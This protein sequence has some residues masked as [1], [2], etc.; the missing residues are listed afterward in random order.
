[1]NRPD[2]RRSGWGL[3]PAPAWV[4]AIAAL[5]LVPPAF[6]ALFVHNHEHGSLVFTFWFYVVMGIV[7]AGY[8]LFAGYVYGDAR[9]R[10]MRATVW[11]VIVVVI[12]NLIGFLLYFVL[13]KPILSPCPQ[14]GQGVAQG[15]AFCSSCGVRQ[16]LI[17]S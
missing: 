14:C 9:R 13:R 4:L 17:T 7:E 1:M 12:P 15:A 3:I 6:H 10:D 11:T 8:I 2:L 16:P 5:V